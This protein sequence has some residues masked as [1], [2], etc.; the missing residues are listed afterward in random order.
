MAKERKFDMTGL[1]VFASGL[2]KIVDG[3]LAV[4]I[5]VF[6]DKTS[7]RGKADKG[8]TNAEIGLI[9]ELG[10]V[11]RKIPRRSF[12]VDTFAFHSD[13]MIAQL[14]PFSEKL[15]LKGKVDE[16]LKLVG[17][18]GKNLVKE[19][20]ETSG[21]GAWPQNSYRT[22]MAKLLGS[23]FKRQQMAA[24]VLFEGATHTKPLIR[25]GQLWQAIDSRTV[26]GNA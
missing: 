13:K 21:W 19:A 7:R 16:Y 24:E 6:G 1:Q 9:H 11:S 12:L 23:R 26:R 15:F 18:A 14:K 17:E 10:S 2:K 3:H 5:G 8:L 22:I 20:F 4:Q 25:S